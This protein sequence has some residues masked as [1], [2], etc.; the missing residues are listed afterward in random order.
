MLR[1]LQGRALARFATGGTVYGY[2]TIAEP[3][4]TDP[5]RLRKLWV[6]DEDEIVRRLFR[7]VDEGRSYRSIADLLNTDIEAPRN[8]GRGAKHGSGWSHVSVRA[9]LV[10][11]KYIGRWIWN[12]HKWTRVPG[13]RARRRT[14]RPSIPELAIVDRMTWSRV[15]GRMVKREHND[16][17]TTRKGQQTTLVSGLLRCG[18]CGGPL[19]VRSAKVKAGVR[20]VNYG[21]TA[22][23][24][25]GGSIC[26]NG[27]A[28][29]GKKMTD[30][31]LAALR[32]VLCGPEVQARRAASRPTSGACAQ[33]RDERD[34]A[35]RRDAGRPRIRQRC[36]S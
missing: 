2:R 20:Y 27:T 7:L 32:D 19:S 10:D 24:S 36:G 15:H 29:S 13:K 12:T 8:N 6:I 14:P 28:I 30:A 3:N 5:E 4:P 18:S 33:A 21:R 17:R 16:E 22:H 1:G 25:R 26:A 31:L 11:E 23:S 34:P 9:I 35:D